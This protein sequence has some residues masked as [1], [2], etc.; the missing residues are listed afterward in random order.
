[1]KGL[2][3][4]QTATINANGEN[5]P[6]DLESFERIRTPLKEQ[7]EAIA[8][9]FRKCL[10]LGNDI[11]LLQEHGSSAEKGDIVTILEDIATKGQQCAQIALQLANG[12]DAV[13]EPYSSQQERFRQQLEHPK[14]KPDARQLEP[15]VSQKPSTKRASKMTKTK[16]S[17]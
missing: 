12:H 1:M 17:E 16:R 5:P 13:L 8:Q 15:M 3:D 4:L 6:S 7:W 14:A 2:Y 9:L 10:S 11:G